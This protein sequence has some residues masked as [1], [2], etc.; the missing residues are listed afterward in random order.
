MGIFSPDLTETAA[1]VLGALGSEKVYVVHGLDGSDEVSI[2][3]DTRV[4]VL[5]DG[6]IET[7]TFSPESVGIPRVAASE[8]AGG[9]P[10]GNAAIIERILGG[11]KSARRDAVVLNA[12]F[13][14]AVAGESTSIEEGVA[15]A[16][17]SIDSGA[18]RDALNRLRTA[19]SR[20]AAQ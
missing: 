9:E 16:R 20:F 1:S 8:I 10:A 7:F 19:S 12:G 5:D 17:E 18:A 11:E 15:A 4:T 6:K 14:I 2:T 13:V 3:A